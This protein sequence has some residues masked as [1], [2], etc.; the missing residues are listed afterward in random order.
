MAFAKTVLVLIVLAAV[1][2]GLYT[3]YR[4]WRRRLR[5]E[6]AELARARRGATPPQ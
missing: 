1:L 4:L 6:S 3:R 2:T 5:G